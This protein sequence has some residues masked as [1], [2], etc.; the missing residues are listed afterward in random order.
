MIIR[1]DL[2]KEI[3]DH[4]YIVKKA[5]FHKVDDVIK[6]KDGFIFID[7]QLG[8]VFD[9]FLNGGDWRYIPAEENVKKRAP[10]LDEALESKEEEKR[11]EDRIKELEEEV[12]RLE[13]LYGDSDSIGDLANISH[14]ID[15]PNGDMEINRK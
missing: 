2:N 6:A 9:P 15:E 11:K 5:G 10:D 3:K 13:E 7:V 4:D 8:E 14:E 1:I 12:R